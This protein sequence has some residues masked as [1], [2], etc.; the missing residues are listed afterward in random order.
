MGNAIKFTERGEVTVQVEQQ[1]EKP[2][3]VVLHI[4][5]ADTGIGI[6]PNKL[7]AIFSAFTQADSSTTRRYGGTGLGLSIS[8]QLVAKFGGRLWVESVVGQGSIFHFITR[9][10]IGSPRPAPL[11]TVNLKDMPVL[12]VDDNSTNRRILEELSFE[13]A[14][15]SEAREMLQLK[16]AEN[17][18]FS[19]PTLTDARH[20]A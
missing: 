2:G 10:A 8:R 6:P 4:S 1:P 3:A 13:I 18:H 17:V 9:F 19:S 12:V 16:G 14:T 20:G 11:T 15:P 7:D 5:V